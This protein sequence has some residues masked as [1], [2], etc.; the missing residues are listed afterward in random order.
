M[1]H[2]EIHKLVKDLDLKVKGLRW[3]KNR[4]R[5]CDGYWRP[6]PYWVAEGMLVGE[7]VKRL[8]EEGQRPELDIVNK[9]WSV[10]T[11]DTPESIYYAGTLLGALAEAYRAVKD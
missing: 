3:G 7:L 5:W 9:R 2:I 10:D 8:A 6:L 11:Y 4:K 1:S